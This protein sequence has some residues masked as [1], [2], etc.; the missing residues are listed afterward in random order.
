MHHLTKRST[1]SP[2][3]FLPLY[4]IF[5]EEALMDAAF[6]NESIQVTRPHVKGHHWGRVELRVVK[7]LS[8]SVGKSGVICNSAA[9]A[10]APRAR[11]PFTFRNAAPDSAPSAQLDFK[12]LWR[13]RDNTCLPKSYFRGVEHELQPASKDWETNIYF[14]AEPP[15]PKSE[16]KWF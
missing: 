1:F 14:F 9:A 2:W 3:M 15:K 8:R 10:A 6:G 11:C 7:C 16:F 13:G 4:K 12:W 5:F